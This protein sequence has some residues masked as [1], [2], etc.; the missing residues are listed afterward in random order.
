VTNEK[1]LIERAGLQ[2]A[3][4]LTEGLSRSAA[5]LVRAVAAAE[6]LFGRAVRT[7]RPRSG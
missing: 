3:D 6:E 4:A 5:D 2:E 1:G 7:A